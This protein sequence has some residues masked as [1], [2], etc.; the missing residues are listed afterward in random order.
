MI[1]SVVELKEAMSDQALEI[2]NNRRGNYYK[3]DNIARQPNDQPEI[4]T[5]LI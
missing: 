3:Y 4:M 1:P 2:D 5:D